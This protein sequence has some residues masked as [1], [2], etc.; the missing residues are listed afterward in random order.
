[1]KTL[2]C[3]CLPDR[4]SSLIIKRI[5]QDVSRQCHSKKALEFQPHFTIR[6]DFKV[7][8][9]NIPELK[10]DIE[11]L[12]ANSRPLN[13]TLTKY[14]FYPW[15]IIFL[16]INK[17]V[18]LQ[19][20]HNSC[21]KIIE[22]YRI[23]W[24]PEKYI[25]NNNFKGKQRKYSLKY[26]YHFCYEFFSPHFTVAGNDMSETSFQKMKKKLAKRIENIKVKVN[27]IAFFDRDKSN[28]IFIKVPF[29]GK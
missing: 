14:G 13:L 4:R 5:S 17:D 15:K 8:V 9:S 2:S 25:N 26:G 23:T 10:I 19:R 3:I 21:M 28:A 7:P 20:L 11:K 1:M 22:K 16:D 12:C 29:G 18:E 27:Q 24:I 6:G